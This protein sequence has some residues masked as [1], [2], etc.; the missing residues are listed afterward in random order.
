MA[1]WSGG[2]FTR[3]RDWTTDEAG[4]VDPTATRFDEED[5]NFAS[6]INACLHKGGQNS[7]TANVNWG[8]YKITNLGAAT[9]TTDVPQY[10]QVA[11]EPV[12]VVDLSSGGTA[13]GIC[14]F[15][16]TP[17]AGWIYKIILKGVSTDTASSFQGLQLSSSA[18]WR[19]T[20][21]YSYVANALT[22]TAASG[23]STPYIPLLY[24][25][26]Y[27][28]ET[29]ANLI[30]GEITLYGLADAIQT[31]VDI[32]LTSFATTTIG[33][34]WGSGI[35]TAAEVQDAVRL[36][37]FTNITGTTDGRDYDAGEAYLYRI[38]EAT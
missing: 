33:H 15:S 36:A 5:D 26:S 8:G 18:S 2:T 17:V 13:T 14:T 28:G 35:R 21:E 7:P 32:R 30:S 19:T 20:N 6:G 23:T 4:A 10:Q 1:G 34:F 22:T 16:H 38:R 12:E 9:A 3:A 11:M 31:A 29:A 27:T 37:L 24:Y 25:D